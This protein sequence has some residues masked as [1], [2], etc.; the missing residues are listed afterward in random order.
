VAIGFV[1]SFISAWVVVKSFLDYVSSHGFA[2]FGWWRI[3]VGAVG[4]IALAL[5][6]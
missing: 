6:G 4:L 3:V 2:V 5:M 1:V